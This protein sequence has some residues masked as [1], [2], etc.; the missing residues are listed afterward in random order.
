[1]KSEVTV[2]FTLT[3]VDLDPDEVTL[4][5]RQQPT[6]AWRVGDAI[7][8]NALVRYQQSGWRLASELPSSSTLEDHVRAVL[9]RLAPVSVAAMELGNRYDAEV[10]CVMRIFG[11]DRPPLHLPKDLVKRVAELNADVDID[12]YVFLTSGDGG[13]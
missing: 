5:L 11:A 1:M 6:K 2:S 7:H 13:S 10:T 9:D 8:P 4:M 12:L 3:A